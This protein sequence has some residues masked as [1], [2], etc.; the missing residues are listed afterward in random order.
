M[1]LSNVSMQNSSFFTICALLWTTFLQPGWVEVSMSMSPSH[2]QTA[3]WL[4][5]QCS[6]CC[7]LGSKIQ[8]GVSPADLYHVMS[9]LSIYVVNISTY[10]FLPFVYH[11]YRWYQL[12]RLLGD[13]PV[14]VHL[15]RRF[16]VHTQVAVGQQASTTNVE[17]PPETR[18]F[19]DM[20]SCLLEMV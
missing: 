9:C 11:I 6:H 14:L 20:T 5:R 18:V 15:L 13:A 17:G 3:P 19:W 10:H 16:A 2:S 1:K 8:L 7:L 12:Q 4:N